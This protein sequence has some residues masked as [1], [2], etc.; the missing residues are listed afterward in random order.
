MHKHVRPWSKE[1]K[2][3]KLNNIIDGKKEDSVIH[4]G[5]W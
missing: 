3:L 5:L 2:I 1:S 4:V